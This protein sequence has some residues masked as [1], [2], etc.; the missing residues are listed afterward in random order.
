MDLERWSSRLTRTG[1]QMGSRMK[2]AA[3]VIALRQRKVSAE[4]KLYDI[5]AEI[6]KKFYEEY[7][8]GELSPGMQAAFVRAEGL[9]AEIASL[10]KAVQEKRGV[11]ICPVCGA[12]MGLD[13][14]FCSSCGTRMPEPEKPEEAEEEPAEE[15]V[16]LEEDT[17]EEEA[18]NEPEE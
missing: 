15:I 12:E 17:T 13:A 10:E 1:R 11:K 4:S 2:E 9:E 18:E 5:Y 7:E 16:E 8:G 3:D 6:G 14:V